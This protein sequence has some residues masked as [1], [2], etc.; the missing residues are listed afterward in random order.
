MKPLR[1]TLL[2]A[3]LFAVSA[4]IPADAQPPARKKKLL[5]IGQTKGFQHDATTHGLATIW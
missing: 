3:A 4:V 1:F 5:A 2:F